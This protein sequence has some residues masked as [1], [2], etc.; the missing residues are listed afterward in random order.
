MTAAN[1]SRTRDVILAHRKKAEMGNWINNGTD[2]TV[3]ITVHFVPKIVLA[4]ASSG[5]P[6]AYSITGQ[7]VSLTF[8]S[9]VNGSFLISE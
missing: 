3:D 4:Q 6:V 7:V 9:G 5:T 8:S 2:T 1:L